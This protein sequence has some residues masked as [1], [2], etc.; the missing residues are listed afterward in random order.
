MEAAAFRRVT[1]ARRG[2]IPR[3]CSLAAGILARNLNAGRGRQACCR[4][5]RHPLKDQTKVADAAARDAMSRALREHVKNRLAPGKCPRWIEFRAD[6]PK[7]ATDKLRRFKLRSE[8]AP[9]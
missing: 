1:N 9:R 8:A 6:L 4:C 3:D 7:A 2:A 5:A